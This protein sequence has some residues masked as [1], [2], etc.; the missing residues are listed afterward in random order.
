MKMDKKLSAS[1]PLIP[2]Q[3][4]CPWTLLEAPPQTR[5]VARNLFRR[6][7]KQG[8]WRQKSPGGVQ[9]HSPGGV[10]GKAPRS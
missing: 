10:W 2:H 5:D 3:G 4:L 6:E 9:G 7:T 1:S 8:D